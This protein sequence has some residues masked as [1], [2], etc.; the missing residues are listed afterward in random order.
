[1]RLTLFACGCHGSASESEARDTAPTPT[2]LPVEAAGASELEGSA[3][4]ARQ[5]ERRAEARSGLRD[6]LVALKEQRFEDAVDAAR[7]S[8]KADPF[9]GRTHYVQARALAGLGREEEAC[10]ALEQT[11]ALL[12]EHFDAWR[13]LAVL[14]EHLGQTERAGAAWA[15]AARTAPDAE[16]RI[17]IERRL[18]SGPPSGARSS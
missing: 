10:T 3:A 16:T 11:V 13:T 8:M 1:M 7:R 15:E 12:P 9:D 5:A 2:P 6:S 4:R 18:S 14:N 17:K